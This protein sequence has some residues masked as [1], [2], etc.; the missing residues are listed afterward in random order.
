MSLATSLT[1]RSPF[2][3]TAK[4]MLAG[5][6]SVAMLAA[7]ADAA[8]QRHGAPLKHLN[9]DKA[10]V[11]L[12]G[13]DPVA[14]FREGGGKAKQGKKALAATVRGVTYRFATAKNLERFEQDP[15]R[16]EPDYGGWCAWAMANNDKVEVDPTSFL[17]EDGRL[18]VFYDGFFNNTRKSWLGKGGTKLRPTADK[19]WN[20]FVG[21]KKGAKPMVRAAKPTLALKGVDPTTVKSKDGGKPG[22]KT[23]VARIGER[24]FQFVS[25]A[26]RTTF[27]K[28]PEA[29]LPKPTGKP[30]G[31]PAGK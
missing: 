5:A 22:L 31:K 7:T 24:Q 30:A 11:A 6:C 9:L 10:R 23:I 3:A 15:E 29:Y 12:S 13:Y 28:N 20:K 19:N 18:L 25:K 8:P 26:A 1:G 17:I 4:A 27:L 21:R 2:S 14:Y 16:F